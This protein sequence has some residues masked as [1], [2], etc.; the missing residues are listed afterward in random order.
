MSKKEKASLNLEETLNIIL[1]YSD[2]ESEDLL[3]SDKSGR[4]MKV[5]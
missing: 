1:A 2:S 3:I 5:A 4:D